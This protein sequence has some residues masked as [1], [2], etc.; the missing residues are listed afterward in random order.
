MII[1]LYFG[2]ESFNALMY[3]LALVGMASQFQHLGLEA[4]AVKEMHIAPD[5]IINIRILK[6]I[7]SLI[8]AVF[9]IVLINK[10]GYPESLVIASYILIVAIILSGEISLQNSIY[11]LNREYKKF[12]RFKLTSAI[13]AAGIKVI[14]IFYLKSLPALIIGIAVYSLL[15]IILTYRYQMPTEHKQIIDWRYQGNLIKKYYLFF[16]GALMMMGTQKIGILLLQNSTHSDNV[17][18]LAFG[19]QLLDGVLLISL[20]FINNITGRLIKISRRGLNQYNVYKKNSKILFIKA[21]LVASITFLSG[22]ISLQFIENEVYRMMILSTMLLMPTL[23]VFVLRQIQSKMVVSRG[24]NTASFKHNAVGFG[25]QLAISYALIEHLGIYAIAGANFI[26][27]VYM[28]VALEL[29]LKS[30]N[31]RTEIQ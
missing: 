6:G 1:P 15:L 31:R 18:A 13:I 25:I 7:F 14:A 23:P 16:A 12:T 20:A 26:A 19:L 3:A 8:G 5:K 22:L 10:S 11:Q 21:S 30:T 29:A 27:F 2:V 24:L 4:G 28:V 17:G 9:Y